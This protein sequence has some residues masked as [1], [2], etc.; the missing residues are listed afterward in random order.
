M[1]RSARNG[2]R[3]IATRWRRERG[4]L[5]VADPDLPADPH[6]L[7]PPGEWF[8]PDAERH[9]L[10]RPRFCPMCGQPLDDGLV[11]ESW[12]GDQRVFLTSCACCSW[13]G[14]VVCYDRVAIHEAMA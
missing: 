7:P 2:W 13:M 4:L 14:D 5:P 8:G 12:A 3:C 11:S 9:L 10:D 6:Q 1:R